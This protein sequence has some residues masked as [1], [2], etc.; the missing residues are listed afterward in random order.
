MHVRTT[1]T[2][3][4]AAGLIG[5]GALALWR[6]HHKEACSCASRVG[7]QPTPHP[8][9][10]ATAASV[11]TELAPWA[12]VDPSFNGCARS[13]GAGP[14][15]K[16]DDAQLQPSAVLGDYTYCP[17]SGALFRI[18][19]NSPKRTV[20]GKAYYFCCETCANYFASHADEVLAKRGLVPAPAL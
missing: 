18:A 14:G 8:P 4:V 12:S 13:C 15:A 19:E 11:R 5:A 2:A 1:W 10:E 16:R 7:Q 3:I 9:D 20:A 17:V 6:E